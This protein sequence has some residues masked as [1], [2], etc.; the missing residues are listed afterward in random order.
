MREGG[1]VII[2]CAQSVR[3]KGMRRKTKTKTFTPFEPCW[4]EMEKFP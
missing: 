3:G 1:G 4:M 2:V